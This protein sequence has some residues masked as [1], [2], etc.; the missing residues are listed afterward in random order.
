MEHDPALNN[1]SLLW[2]DLCLNIEVKNI[3]VS[4]VYLYFGKPPN[5]ALNS[6]YPHCIENPELL[7]ILKF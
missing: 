1:K 7:L 5:V 4:F 3:S 6:S 2:M